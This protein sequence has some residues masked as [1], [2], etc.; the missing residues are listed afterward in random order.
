L[1]VNLE[2]YPKI[3]IL[4]AIPMVKQPNFGFDQ[5]FPPK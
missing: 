2:A 1:P 5:G 3:T 4:D